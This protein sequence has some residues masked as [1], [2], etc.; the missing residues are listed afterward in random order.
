MLPL[1]SMHGTRLMCTRTS[2]SP[3]VFMSCNGDKLFLPLL[4]HLPIWQVCILF[5]KTLL[6][7]FLGG[8]IKQVSI[9]TQVLMKVQK[10][11]LAHNR[12]EK[13]A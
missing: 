5:Y 8:D 1:N 9:L 11:A 4:N 7:V 12:E 6:V 10:E 3:W 13:E 2:I